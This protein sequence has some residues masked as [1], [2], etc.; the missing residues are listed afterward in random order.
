VDN[1]RPQVEIAEVWW[2]VTIGISSGSKT[3]PAR[4]NPDSI[5]V[6]LRASPEASPVLVRIV[7]R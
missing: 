4:S 3:R 1:T 7:E 6:A 5:E 2:T